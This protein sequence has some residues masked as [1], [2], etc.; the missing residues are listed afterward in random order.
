MGIKEQLLQ[1]FSPDDIFLLGAPLFME[2]PQNCS[3]LAQ[4]ESQLLDEV[5]SLS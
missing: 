3:P 4:K 1:K 5:L 2:T